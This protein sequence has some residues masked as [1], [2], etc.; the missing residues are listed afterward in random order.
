MWCGA[1]TDRESSA[2]LHALYHI[3][4]ILLKSD[5]TIQIANTNIRVSE[6]DGQGRLWGSTYCQGQIIHCAGCTL[7]GGPRRHAVLTLERAK[8]VGKLKCNDDGDD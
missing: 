2:K 6:L 5:N 3:I 1:I 4:W 7:R 8:R